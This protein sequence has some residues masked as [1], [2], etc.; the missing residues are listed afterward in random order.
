MRDQAEQ[1]YKQLRSHTNIHIFIYLLKNVSLI[2]VYC[3]YILAF[4]L[5][6]NHNSALSLR[7]LQLFFFSTSVS[8]V[9]SVNI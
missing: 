3:I 4:I 9:Q 1:E 5:Y 6:C 7:V 8:R 2:V